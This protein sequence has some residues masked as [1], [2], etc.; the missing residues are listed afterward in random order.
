MKK[1]YIIPTTEVT[2]VVAEQMIA[3]SITGV[4][5]DSGVTPADPTDPVPGEA[6]V[7]G[8]SYNVWDIDWSK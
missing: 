6:D 5:G 8:N 4:G 1:T 2:F 3:N 7:K